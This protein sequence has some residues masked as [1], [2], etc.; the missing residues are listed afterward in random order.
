MAWHEGP[1]PK[2]SGDL[3][4]MVRLQEEAARLAAQPVGGGLTVG[5][6]VTRAAEM[7]YRTVGEVTQMLEKSGAPPKVVI[8]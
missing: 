1:P 6:V 2:P 7:G 8:V 5:D 3:A 4:D